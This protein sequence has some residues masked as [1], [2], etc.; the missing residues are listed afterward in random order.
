M[1]PWLY[2]TGAIVTEVTAT[3]CLRASGGFAKLGFTAVVVAA[4]VASFWF[5]AQALQHGMSLGVAYGVWSGIGIATIAVLGKLVFDEGL[6][7]V[8]AAGLA[9]IVLG[10]VVV[11]LGGTHADA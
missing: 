9:L 10:V 2:L 6:S 5:L 11:Q 1:T 4:Y 3:M 8:T 7:P